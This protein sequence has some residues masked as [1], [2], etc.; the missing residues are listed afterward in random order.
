ME[1]LLQID[2]WLFDCIN[3]SMSNPIFDW[4]MPLLREKLVWVP[5]YVYLLA[6]ACF[7]LPKAQAIAM[8]LGLVLSVGIADVLSSKVIKPF[9]ARERP[10]QNALLDA[11]II[12]RVPCGHGYS[13]TSSHACNHFAVAGFLLFLFGANARIWKRSI[14]LWAA[15]ICFAQVYVGVHYPSDVIVGGALGF[16]IGWSVRKLGR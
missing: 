5:L 2:Q 11:Q 3:Q 13:F 14:V 1:F 15:V 9:I 12:E 8:I 4:L 7:R 10:C 6:F 16:A